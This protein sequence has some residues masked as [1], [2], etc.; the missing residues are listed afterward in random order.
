MAGDDRLF[1]LK[2][3]KQT[4]IGD[5]NL[6]SLF[7]HEDFVTTF[8]AGQYN[9]ELALNSGWSEGDW[10]DD[11]DFTEP[12]IVFAL[13]AGNYSPETSAAV[14]ISVPEPSTWS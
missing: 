4:V 7:D 5:S 11:G 12:N 8:I 14:T 2:A 1:W 10:D 6:H 9:D 13:T 3:P